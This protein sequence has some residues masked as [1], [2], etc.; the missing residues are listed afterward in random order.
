[1]RIKL[2]E[3][4][5]LQIASR[6][7]TLGHEVHT[8]QQEGLLGCADKEIWEAAQREERCLV[9]QDLDFSD[10]RRFA[11]GTHHGVLLLRLHSAGRLSLIERVEELFRCED[12]DS[13][14]GCFVV[15]TEQKV[16]VRRPARRPEPCP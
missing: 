10:A 15:A 3:N 14:V 13:W 9:T 11:P 5:P 8:T 16:R 2:D 6:L 7:Q 4:L 12:V 1:M